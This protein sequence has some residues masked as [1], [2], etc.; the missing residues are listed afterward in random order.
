M[1]DGSRLYE[2]AAAPPGPLWHVDDGR[3]FFAGTLDYNASHQHGAPVYLAGLHRPFGLRVAGGPWLACR[4]AVIPAGVLHELDVGGDPIAVLYVEPHAG[5]LHALL[6]LV[7]GAREVGGALVGDGGEVSLLRTLYEDRSSPG[8]AGEA[9]R[10]LVGFAAPRAAR[11]IDGRIARVVADLHGDD[12]APAP[13]ARLAAG[14]GLS[15]SRFQ[16]LFTGEV[17][18][19]FRRYRAWQ[20]MRSAIREI[21]A[22]N[23]FTAA[24]H[25]AGFADQ[26]HFAHDFRRTFGA[27]ASRSLTGV[28]RPAG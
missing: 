11:S 18:V 19:P 25:A 27:P 22:G 10:D 12:G 26:P 3:T 5:G 21:V 1:A 14:V 17:G 4:T 24:A 16:H 28:R 9:L 20:R 2:R 8:W 13:V 7:R 15:A 6:P 23:S